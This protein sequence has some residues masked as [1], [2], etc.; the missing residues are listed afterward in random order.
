MKFNAPVGRWNDVHTHDWHLFSREPIT[1]TTA[2]A[3]TKEEDT[4]GC[5]DIKTV[6]Y[7]ETWYCTGC[8]VVEER[9]APV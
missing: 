3:P 4:W 2:V 5:W 8:R 9:E 7:I 1:E 6:G